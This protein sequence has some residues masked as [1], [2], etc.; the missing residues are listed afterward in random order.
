MKIR[1]RFPLETPD[2]AV[3]LFSVVFFQN[4]CYNLNYKEKKTQKTLE[5]F[6][7]LTIF[8]RLSEEF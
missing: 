5:T 7:L 8:S 4:K 6:I 3:Q 1:V 2:P